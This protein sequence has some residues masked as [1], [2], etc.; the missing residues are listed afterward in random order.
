[1]K[2]KPLVELHADL[3]DSHSLFLAQLASDKFR[4]F[5]NTSEHNS[6]WPH[7]LFTTPN[8]FVATGAYKKIHQYSWH[9]THQRFHQIVYGRNFLIR[10]LICMCWLCPAQ[11]E[12]DGQSTSLN[13]SDA[14]GNQTKKVTLL[15]S[16]TAW[17]LNDF[18]SL[19]YAHQLCKLRKFCADCTMHA[20]SACL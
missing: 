10:T 15:R 18:A 14:D 1:M 5:Q 20:V 11:C 3:D 6:A 4:R 2:R 12:L 7:S 17:K 8:M 13:Q 9:C 16:A 19:K